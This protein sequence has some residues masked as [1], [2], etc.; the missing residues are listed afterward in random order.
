[1]LPARL[2]S[3]TD[4]SNDLQ[5]SHRKSKAH[6]VICFL[7]QGRRSR[8]SSPPAADEFP[9][10]PADDEPVLGPEAHGAAGPL[11]GKPIQ[12]WEVLVPIPKQDK[13][14]AA[15]EHQQFELQPESPESLFDGLSQGMGRCRN[16]DEALRL[17]AWFERGLD[18]QQDNVPGARTYVQFADIL[19]RI[20]SENCNLSQ[21][22]KEEQYEKAVENHAAST[23]VTMGEVDFGKDLAADLKEVF[24]IDNFQLFCRL[25][26][27][28]LRL[29]AAEF[30]HNIHADFEGQG[31]SHYPEAVQGYKDFLA[32]RAID[33]SSADYGAGFYNENKHD[34]QKVL[35]EIWNMYLARYPP[36]ARG[37]EIS[38]SGFGFPAYAHLLDTLFEVKKGR[39]LVAKRVFDA[40]VGAVTTFTEGLAATAGANCFLLFL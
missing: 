38:P 25:Q 34:W 30:Q 2:R 29:P 5:F 6:L 27:F 13:K 3:G 32:S 36:Q 1:M 26:N 35:S 4:L 24:G 18:L 14:P 39:V 28:D 9:S 16:K 23:L 40:M 22:L 19:Y 8:D 12:G 21:D 33:T 15:E 7:A 11:L 10:P 37:W 31:E 17:W 20:F